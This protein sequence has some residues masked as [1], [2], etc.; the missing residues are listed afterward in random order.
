MTDAELAKHLRERLRIDASLPDA[1]LVI[2]YA[3]GGGLRRILARD[4]TAGD[5]TTLLN[6]HDRLRAIEKAARELI[7]VPAVSQALPFGI[8]EPLAKR[9]LR[10]L[11]KAR[12]KRLPAEVKMLVERLYQCRDDPEAVSYERANTGLY[13]ESADLLVSLSAQVEL[14]L[15]IIAMMEAGEKVMREKLEATIARAEKAEA[16]NAQLQGQFKDDLRSS[17]GLSWKDATG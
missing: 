6:A 5:L 17:H 3:G 1:R 10:E 8:A 15:Q 14:H 11:A 4:F 2:A 13:D 7:V 16:A 9:I 12:A